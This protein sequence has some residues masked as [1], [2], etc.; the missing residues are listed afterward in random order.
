MGCYQ[1]KNQMETQKDSG[2]RQG[3]KDHRTPQQ[4]DN[5]TGTIGQEGG[6]DRK[7][8]QRPFEP[9][10]NIEDQVTGNKEYDRHHTPEQLRRVRAAASAEDERQQ[11]DINPDLPGNRP[12]NDM[13]TH[14]EDYDGASS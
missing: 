3:N 1:K 14:A 4:S 9:Q 2:R 12:N 5:N 11:E 10:D 13:T 6:L 7:R 8:E